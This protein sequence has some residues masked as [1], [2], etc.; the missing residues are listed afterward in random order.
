MSTQTAL[1][2]IEAA[3]RMARR[4]VKQVAWTLPGCKI[5]WS[6]ISADKA[7]NWDGS[8]AGS[9]NDPNRQILQLMVWR[10]GGLPRYTNW[11]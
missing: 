4:G 1:N 7:R 5:E 11:W 2:G 6:Y 8:P 9:G 10:E 3:S